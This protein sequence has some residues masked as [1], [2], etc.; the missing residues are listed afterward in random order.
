MTIRQFST[1]LTHTLYF[2]FWDTSGARTSVDSPIVD[3]L[4]PYKNSYVIAG[5]LTTTSTTGRYA[6][7]TFLEPGLTVGHYFARATGLTTN[8][9]LYSESQV[10][11]VINYT[12]EPLW[13]GL[14][15]LRQHL[16]LADD[17]RDDD[18]NLRQ[19]LAAAL[20]LVEGH[21]HRQYGVRQIDEV[22]QVRNSDR[23]ILKNHP[24]Q[25]IIG[26][27]PSLKI[28][29][30]TI[31]NLLVETITDS[32]VSF[33]FRPDYNNGIIY[34]TDSAGYDMYYDEL[35]LAISYY[36][37]FATVPEPVRH[38][39]LSLA[40]ALHAMMCTEGL[41]SVKI[42]DISFAHQRHLFDGPIGDMLKPYMNNFKV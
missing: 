32:N 26:M 27:T 36:A 23:V 10:F 15:E 29:P 28:M 8:D 37:G 39:V 21:T 25:S 3:I 30:R 31:D 19:A 42:S 1:G 6:Y 17:D 12:Y 33:Y 9:T 13:V 2:D 40:S 22:I 38:A 18:Q 35:L 16:S 20:E 41:T 34:L 7:Q 14:D 5:G 24:V 4:D 11:E